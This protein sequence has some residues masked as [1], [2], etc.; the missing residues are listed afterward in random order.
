MEITV[1]DN[2]T[3][4]SRSV[5]T[6]SKLIHNIFRLGDDLVSEIPNSVKDSIRSLLNNMKVPQSEDVVNIID[7]NY[8]R[9]TDEMYNKN[10]E[11]LDMLSRNIRKL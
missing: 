7:M 8:N 5:R 10:K 11:K 9:I 1:I 6:E 4:N 2:L 3:E